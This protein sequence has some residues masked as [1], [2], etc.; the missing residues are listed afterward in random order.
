MYQRFGTAIALVALLSV[1]SFDRG[2]GRVE[3]P[4]AYETVVPAAVSQFF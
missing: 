4:K 2:S 3:K 1:I